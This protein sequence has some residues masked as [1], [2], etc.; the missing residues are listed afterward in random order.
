MGMRI[1][2]ISA[3][4][5]L[6]LIGCNQPEKEK[7]LR[8]LEQ[9]EEKLSVYRQTVGMLHEDLAKL[10]QQFEVAEDNIIINLVKEFRVYRTKKERAERIEHA[11][12]TKEGLE[13][14]IEQ[15]ILKINT[16]S[17]SLQTTEQKIRQA[18]AIL[19]D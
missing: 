10:Q 7:V 15:T 17:D 5:L 8:E 2:L 1:F 13:Q 14:S 19:N 3:S 12:A 18:K 11:V 9:S 6:V 4:F 16:L